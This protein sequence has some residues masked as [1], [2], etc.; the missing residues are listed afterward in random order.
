MKTFEFFL[1][2][3]QKLIGSGRGIFMAWQA[4]MNDNVM[5]GDGNRYSFES[6]VRRHEIV[7]R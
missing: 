2:N 7:F 3:G 5:Y 1:R 6:D 4:A